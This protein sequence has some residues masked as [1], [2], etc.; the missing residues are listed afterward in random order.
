[1]RGSH[2]TSNN[3]ILK[4]KDTNLVTNNTSE[5]SL[6]NENMLSDLNKQIKEK[7]NEIDKL[8]RTNAELKKKKEQLNTKIN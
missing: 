3:Q 2:S 5:K 1:M 6:N 7:N 4:P 8:T